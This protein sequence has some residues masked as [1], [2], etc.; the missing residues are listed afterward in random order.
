M[1]AQPDRSVPTTRG[2]YRVI[3]NHSVF[4]KEPGELLEVDMPTSAFE[5]LVEGNHLDPN[6][7]VPEKSEPAKTEQAEQPVP[8]VHITDGDSVQG[9][10]NNT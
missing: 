4:G 5:A 3:G 6:P 10:D 9:A 7:V 1:V 2:E 8:V